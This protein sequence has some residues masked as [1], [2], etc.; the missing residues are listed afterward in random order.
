MEAQFLPDARED[1]GRETTEFEIETALVRVD[2]RLTVHEGWTGLHAL[3][4]GAR[5]ARRPR[6]L[7]KWRCLCGRNRAHV[8]IRRKHAPPSHM[9]HT[10]R[11]THLI[12]LILLVWASVA[13][14]VL[15]G[16]GNGWRLVG[17]DTVWTAMLGRV[18]TLAW[19][20]GSKVLLGGGVRTCGV[21]TSGWDRD[22]VWLRASADHGERHLSRVT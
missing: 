10:G 16:M 15:G 17:I 22:A 11:R 4:R 2:G 8:R 6:E 7:G 5:S 14:L 3:S 20:E 13:A 1:I 21:R 12:H 19:H 9:S 18:R